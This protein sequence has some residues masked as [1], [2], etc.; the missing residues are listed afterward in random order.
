MGIC[1]LLKREVLEDVDIG[2]AFL[3]DYRGKG[4]ATESCEAMM[5]YARDNFGID[6]VVAVV[7]PGNE[8]SQ[9]VLM[10][11]GLQFDKMIRLAIDAPESMLFSPGKKAIHLNDCDF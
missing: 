7:S 11:L 4:F 1:G 10:K 2:Y 9:R 3:P 5:A 8:K 6:R